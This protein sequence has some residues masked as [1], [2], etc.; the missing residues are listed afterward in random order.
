MWVFAGLGSMSLLSWCENTVW[1]GY[2]DR[3]K[4]VI[5]DIE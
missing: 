2:S 5:K 3:Y 1:V 4:D